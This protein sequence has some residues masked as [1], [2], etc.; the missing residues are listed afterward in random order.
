VAAAVA[1]V[2]GLVFVFEDA[3]ISRSRSLP[4]GSHAMFLALVHL[5]V[6]GIGLL[7]WLLARNVTKLVIDRR[8]GI[9]GSKLNS[10]FVALFVLTSAL[11]TS[12]LFVLCGF[13]VAHTVDTWFELE[14]SD[15]LS[16]A[17]ALA[18]RYYTGEE[19]TLRGQARALAR[20][21]GEFGLLEPERRTGLASWL[22]N[23]RSAYGLASIEVFDP[24]LAPIAASGA[25]GARAASPDAA[26][27]RSS[28]ALLAAV[29]QSG[30]ASSERH[31]VPEGDL[32]RGAATI[33]VSSLGGEP[34]G[35]VLIERLLP[36]EIGARVTSVHEALDAYQR[37]QPAAGPFRGSMLLLL[38][39]LTLLS[40]LF[41]SW[42][43]FRLAKQITDPI[44][45][46][47]LAADEVAAG[48]LEV[49][50]EHRGEDE[51]GLLVAGFNRMA[52]DLEASRGDLE[53]RRGLM[54]VVLGGVGAGVISVDANGLVTTVNAS[55]VR[56]LGVAPGSWVGAKLG[57]MLRD[58]P[59]DVA[60]HL[61][62]RLH[63]EGREILR[64]QVAISV[65]GEHRILNW[66]VSALRAGD[67]AYAGAVALID[68]VTQIVR[69]Q[70][71]AAWRDV[72]R[73]IAHEVKNPLTPIQLSAQ[74]LRRKLGPRISDVESRQVL[75]QCT[76]A[77]TA[78]V[79]AMK[80]LVSEFSKFA[81]LPATDPTP[82]DLNA[83]VSEAI[84]MYK[85]KP[86]I[87]F[88]AHLADDLPELDVD[89]E[90][91]KRVILNLVDNAMVAIEAAGSGPRA[92]AISTRIDRAV[93]T[94]QLE[95]ADTGCG[96]R[97]E[98]RARLFQ[99]GFSTKKDGT[100]IGLTIVSRIVSD[101]SGHI[102]VRS[103]QPR[104]TRF[105][106]ELPAR[107]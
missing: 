66:T 56:L 59:L 4:I 17:R 95:V 39:L 33:R 14:L 32:L 102:R 3:V 70:R 30:Q 86:S 42:M 77:I 47:A 69:G 7:A 13:L 85:G 28:P 27:A 26:A 9:V 43:G 75:E 51:I 107:L 2:L 20:E 83:L 71:T 10:K 64:Q 36:P 80:V 44:Q 82:T 100:G 60:D 67:G 46:L 40:L 45:R 61:L 25:D 41:S 6:I 50:V 94:V 65:D 15:G 63:A 106:I 103:N 79:E 31:A 12:G 89:R 58:A 97:P 74:R 54:E 105:V 73:R 84:A 24:R 37:L 62:S 81:A 48:N 35:V 1:L 57:E 22:R 16:A 52:S 72:A 98:D 99:P 92:I 78:Q 88:T 34:L 21:I 55:A 91:I 96:V 76:D 23:R 11:S 18:D 87:A 38:G 53:R 68:D 5:N 8:R 19:R 29:G 101:H 90:Q 104:G 49:R 93:G